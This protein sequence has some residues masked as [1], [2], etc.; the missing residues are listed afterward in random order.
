MISHTLCWDCKWAACKKR[1]DGSMCQWAEELTPIPGWTAVPTVRKE[2]TEDEMRSFLVISCPEFT[3]DACFGGQK[4][5]EEL[6]PLEAMKV[7]GEEK[8]R[9]G[10][11]KADKHHH[12]EKQ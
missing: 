11:T 10:Y 3:R 2:G 5:P 7:L 12:P 6:T 9:D 1:E 4:R 8:A